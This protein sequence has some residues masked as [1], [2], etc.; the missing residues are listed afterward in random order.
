MLEVEG[1]GYIEG[2]VFGGAPFNECTLRRGV[3][4]KVGKE[5]RFAGKAQADARKRTKND[6]FRT[7]QK[8]K[9]EGVRNRNR[10]KID[11]ADRLHRWGRAGQRGFKRKKTKS[12]ETYKKYHTRGAR[13]KNISTPRRCGVWVE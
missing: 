6:P 10:W 13:G 5:K 11:P 9:G 8:K 12:G 4:S 2:G 1:I 7:Q 3:Y